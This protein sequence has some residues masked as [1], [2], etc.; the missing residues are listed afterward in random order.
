[1]IDIGGFD[2]SADDFASRVTIEDVDGGATVQIG[3]GVLTLD[4]VSAADL[5]VDD[6]VSA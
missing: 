1:M 2:I 3:D 6:F 4:G 5:T